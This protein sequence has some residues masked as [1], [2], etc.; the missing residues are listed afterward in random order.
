MRCRA[1]GYR[2]YKAQ[3]RFTSYNRL[4][5]DEQFKE[6]MYNICARYEYEEACKVFAD[7][8][9]PLFDCTFETGD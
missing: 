5:I 2:N 1:V 9:C 8:V 6:D 3:G 7:A 4:Q